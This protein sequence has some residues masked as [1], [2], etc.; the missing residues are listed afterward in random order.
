MAAKMATD[1]IRTHVS[2]N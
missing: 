2:N 1:E